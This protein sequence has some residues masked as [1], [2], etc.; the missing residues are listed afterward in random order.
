MAGWIEQ[1]C[2]TAR[3][4]DTRTV[5][6]LSPSGA[7]VDYEFLMVPFQWRLPICDVI[8]EHSEW[9]DWESVLNMRY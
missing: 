4:R 7:R 3:Y 6:H 1:Q 5:F 8:D 2:V 9:S